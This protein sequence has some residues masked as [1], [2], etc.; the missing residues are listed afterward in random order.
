MINCAKSAGDGSD[1]YQSVLP[2]TESTVEAAKT[3]YPTGQ[4]VRR[5]EPAIDQ[6]SL[7]Y[8]LKVLSDKKSETIDYELRLWSSID[9]TNYERCFVVRKA[10]DK[11]S[12]SIIEPILND[13]ELIQNARKLAET[14]TEQLSLPSDGWPRFEEL[15]N[16]N[17]LYPPLPYE[18]DR[19]SKGPILDEGGIDLEVRQG[20][21]YD[22]VSYLAFTDSV[23]GRRVIHICE[24]IEKLFDI[25]IGCRHR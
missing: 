11:W 19:S 23:D 9:L 13:G 22:I 3:P 8:G 5:T 4:T 6:R 16:R 15:I 10:K 25:R 21:N 14:K 24:E 1:S 18:L 2:N 17:S 20:K 7:D 12:A